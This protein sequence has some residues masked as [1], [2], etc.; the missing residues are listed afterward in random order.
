[1]KKM[2]R[3]EKIKKRR[4]RFY[5]EIVKSIEEKSRC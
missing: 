2:Q 1:M 5:R 3:W 4:T